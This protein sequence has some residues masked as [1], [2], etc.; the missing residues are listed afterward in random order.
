M[1]TDKRAT[2]YCGLG[3]VENK[4]HQPV[5]KT[6]QQWQRWA[7]KEAR[8]STKKATAYGLVAWIDHR[9]AYRISFAG[10]PVKIHAY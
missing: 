7:D 1:N 5:Y 8:K 10:Q 3:L 2:A 4:N 6:R 9:Q